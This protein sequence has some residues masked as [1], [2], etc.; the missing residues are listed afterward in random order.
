VRTL[1]LQNLKLHFYLLLLFLENVM[2]TENK[3][4][5][6]VLVALVT[7]LVA[8]TGA[9]AAADAGITTAVSTAT[10]NT[11]AIAAG[12]LAMAVVFFGLGLIVSWMRK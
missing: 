4:L 1:V 7:G 12:V 2:K 5:L 6:L 8:S 10:A 3:K 9:F 11:A